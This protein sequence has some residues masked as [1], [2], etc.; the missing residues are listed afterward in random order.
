MAP[1][2]EK[3]IQG[4]AADE[5]AEPGMDPNEQSIH[6]EMDE[7]MNQYLDSMGGSAEVGQ[8]MS[9]PI[10]AVHADNVLG[11]VGGKAEGIVPLREIMESADARPPRPGDKIDVIVK[12]QDSETGLMLLSHTEAR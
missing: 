6:H 10:V 3:S 7:M 5:M 4:T 9:V 1:Q 11:D 12:G 2:Q 8:A